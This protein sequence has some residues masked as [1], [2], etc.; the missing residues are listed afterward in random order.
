MTETTPKII[1]PTKYDSLAF[2]FIE[3]VNK[4][5]KT[6]FTGGLL[7]KTNKLRPFSTISERVIRSF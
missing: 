5:K 7:T 4:R 2:Q 6:R 3:K 1:K